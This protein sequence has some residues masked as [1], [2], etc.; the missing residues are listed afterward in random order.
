MLYLICFLLFKITPNVYY[1]LRT[2]LEINLFFLFWFCFSFGDCFGAPAQWSPTFF[3]LLW[4]TIFPWTR[5]WG[6]GF[7]MIPVPY[8]YCAL[9]SYYYYISSSSDPRLCGPLNQHS[10]FHLRHLGITSV[11]LFFKLLKYVWGS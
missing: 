5:G 11:I 3:G 10:A 4:K 9:Y 1:N 8:I 6:D 7:W 2:S